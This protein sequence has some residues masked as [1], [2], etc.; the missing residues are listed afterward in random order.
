MK[1]FNRHLDFSVLSITTEPELPA[2]DKDFLSWNI[3]EWIR[4]LWA[5]RFQL[6]LKAYQVIALKYVF[7]VNMAVV[8][9]EDKRH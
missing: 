6:T 5:L 2:E 9:D 8:L 4:E 1:L 3:L 7:L